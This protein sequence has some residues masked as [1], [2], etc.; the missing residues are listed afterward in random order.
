MSELSHPLLRQPLLGPD[1][2]LS[3][4]W[5]EWFQNL[6]T[7]TGSFQALTNLDLEDEIELARADSYST[8][9]SAAQAVR[10]VSAEQLLSVF[11]TAPVPQID[12][13]LS[14]LLAFVGSDTSVLAEVRKAVRDVEIWGAFV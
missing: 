14:H 1:G 9:A 7:R 4:P 6:F 3:R 11:T 5:Q 2:R 8:L 13:M 10:D 12:D